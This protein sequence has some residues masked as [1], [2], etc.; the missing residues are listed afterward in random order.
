MGGGGY[1]KRAWNR[2]K[3]PLL[4]AQRAKSA[5]PQD[6]QNQQGVRARSAE[7]SRR[8]WRAHGAKLGVWDPNDT[9]YDQDFARE[10]EDA[11]KAATEKEDAAVARHQLIAA[12]C[13]GGW[14]CLVC[15]WLLI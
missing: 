7:E 2:L 10:V 11:V 12:S 1:L 14:V 3:G 6:M 15:H 4:R 13:C 8:N 9:R 5:L